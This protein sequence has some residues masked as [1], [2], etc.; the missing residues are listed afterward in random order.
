MVMM[1]EAVDVEFIGDIPG[2]PGHRRFHLQALDASQVSYEMRS[3]DDESV[4]LIA[5]PSVVFFRDYSPEIDDDTATALGLDE[6]TAATDALVLLV[7]TLGEA[8][9]DSTANQLA[10][11]IVNRASGR[12]VQAIMDDPVRFPIRVALATE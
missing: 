11:I 10:P 3:V 5:V 9:A 12:A 4:R 7:V 2:F 6:A 8:L 1:N